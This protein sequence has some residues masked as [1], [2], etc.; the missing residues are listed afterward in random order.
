MK[1]C[2]QI[3]YESFKG[4]AVPLQTWRGPEG[5]R[6]LRLPGFVTT[7]QDDGK[8]VSLTHWPLFTPR[9]YSRYSFLLEAE[10]TPGPQRDRKDFMSMKNPLAP[11]GIEPATFRY[12]AQ[13]L[14]QY[15]S[16]INAKYRRRIDSL[17]A[18][19]NSPAN[20][21]HSVPLEVKK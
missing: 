11:P 5:S 17:K 4:K 2:S 21:S 20:R 10:S 7:A 3:M 6:K 12:V 8:V 9:K 19:Q 18:N 13:H 14:N 15:E 1:Q 16:V